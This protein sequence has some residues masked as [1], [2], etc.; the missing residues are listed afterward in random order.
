MTGVQTCA[1]PISIMNRLTIYAR[2]LADNP[3]DIPAFQMRD[4]PIPFGADLTP[5]EAICASRLIAN[6]GAGG[7]R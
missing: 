3:L 7:G 2:S 6:L 1:L 5:I 4:V